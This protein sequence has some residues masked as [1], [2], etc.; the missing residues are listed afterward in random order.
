MDVSDQIIFITLFSCDLAHQ[1]ERK[2]YGTFLYQKHDMWDEYYF[3]II[4]A[5][6]SE[7]DEQMSE[8]LRT[9]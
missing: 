9:L 8:Y 6:K 4:D 7:V 3:P 1:Y 5:L 2:I